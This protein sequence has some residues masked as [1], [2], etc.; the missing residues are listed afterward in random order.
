[1]NDTAPNVIIIPAKVETPQEQEKKRHLRVAA[2]CRVSTDS[3]EQLSSYENQLAYYTDKIMK[4]PGWTMAGVFADEGI[5]GT[6]T[7]KRKEFLRMIRQC[8]QGKIDMILAKSISRF[9]RNT[10]DTLN[11]TRELRSLGI[12]VIFE[13]QNINSIYPESEFLITLHGAFAQAES[14]ST[15]SRV[16]WGKRQAMKSGHAIMQYKWLLGYEKG[17]DGKPAIVP[18]QAE[19]VRFIYDRYLAGDTLQGIKE[20]LEAQRR[21]TAA[22]NTTWTTVN[23]RSILT[24]EKYCGDVL[25][26]KTFIADCISKKVIPNTGQL[27]KYLIQNHHEGIVSRE[28]FDAVQLEMVRR[29]AKAGAT[30]KSTPTGRGKYSGKHVLSNLLF[31]GECGTAYRR[32]VWTQHGVKRPVW[33]CVSRLDYG[34]KFCTHSPTMDEEPL[35]QAILAAVNAVMLDRGALARQLA[36]AMERELAPVLG[37][38]MSLA[39]IDRALEELSSQFNSLLAE[40]SANPAE[41]YTERFRE[42][43]EST[44]RLKEQKAELEGVYQKQSQIQKRLRAV[45]SAMEHMTA[46]LTE[47]DEEIIH[48]LLEKVTVLSREK[49]RVTFRD[50]REVEQAVNQPKRKCITA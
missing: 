29:N 14:E 25:L 49:I 16:R 18:E 21:L 23:I 44:A 41:D 34:K 37:E 47:W 48:Q 33:R 24:N 3:E 4:E 17:A 1:M 19:T 40:A 45:S 15:S 28:T 22:G 38:S 50:G 6:S 20:A 12:P 30:R 8:R 46:E 10:V 2:Y 5:T 36:V 27:P 26:Q 13:E 39:D 35:Q 7:C 42:L 32:C 31:C 43:S 9:A 11:F